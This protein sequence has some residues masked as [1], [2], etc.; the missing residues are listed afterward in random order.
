MDALHLCENSLPWVDRGGC[1]IFM[2][3]NRPGISREGSYIVKTNATKGA[4]RNPPARY[5]GYHETRYPMKH[6]GSVHHTN[7]IL[8]A[9]SRKVKDK[10][11]HFSSVWQKYL[12]G[13]DA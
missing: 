9:T 13:K 6:W 5:A 8:L 1:V 4:K 10:S 7:I 3:K 2:H 11:A 12:V